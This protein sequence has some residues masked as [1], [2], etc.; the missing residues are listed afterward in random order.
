MAEPPHTLS[1]A[2]ANVPP[3]RWG[4][5][6]SGGADSV[7]LLTMLSGRADLA[8]HVIH[9]DH[10][11]RGEASAG[12]ARFVAALANQ[13]GLPCTV[14]TRAETEPLLTDL[15]ANPSARYRAL[16]A[17]LYCR[18]VAGH[19]L[20][21]IVLA[22]HAD[23]QAETV[24]HRLLR[25]SGVMGLGGMAGR[26]T[27]G[28]LLILR[29][30]LGVRR[31]QLRAFL[32]SRGQ[33]WREDASNQSG[34]YLR[35][36]LRRGLAGQPALTDA[37]LALGEACAELREWVRG[38]V[39]PLEAVLPVERLRDLP[40][41][42]ARET[43]RQWLT[44]RGVPDHE[45]VPAVLDRLLAMAADAASP[46]RRHFPGRVLVRRW[47]GVLFVDPAVPGGEGGGWRVGS[48]E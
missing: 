13:M 6:V 16:R 17:A 10:Q 19:G 9:L 14:A 36:R 27:V 39:P 44:G 21:G 32:A 23:D 1:D 20:E 24:L 12:D 15:P 3:G 2:I 18:V 40:A 8:L 35:N 45:I 30:L 34:Q 28:G 38:Q 26:T 5:G 43:A 41:L 48:G 4:V 31:E 33:P 22:H 7:A 25:G 42:V 29:P 11:T 46:P 47:G 37:L